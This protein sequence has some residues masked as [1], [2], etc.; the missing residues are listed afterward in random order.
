MALIILGSDSLL[1][2]T[3]AN[4]NFIR[5]SQGLI[6]GATGILM[7][8]FF[9]KRKKINKNAL[10]AFAVIVSLILSVLVNGMSGGAFLKIFLLLFG[11]FASRLVK[12]DDFAKYYINFMKFIAIVS[13]L[14][15]IFGSIIINLNV[16]PI[17]SNYNNLTFTSLFFTNIPI[18]SVIRHRNFGPFWEPGVYQAYLFI[19]L[20]FSLFIIKEKK[21]FNILL[22]VVTII[23]TFST[24]GYLCMFLL[25][26]AYMIKKD[27]FDTLKNKVLM[28]LVFTSII[29][30]LSFDQEVSQILF[31]KI[32]DGNANASFGSR[33]ESVWTNLKIFSTNPLFGVGPDNVLAKFNAF[34]STYA[35]SS[36]I[37]NTNTIF[38]HF[39]SFG[40]LMGMYYVYLMYKFATKNNKS[41]MSVLI[42]LI[43]LSI[44]LSAE[45]FIYSI[46]FNTLFFYG[47]LSQNGNH[48][49]YLQRRRF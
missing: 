5:F 38:S 22:F 48:K 33:F 44:I 21:K 8:L 17:I 16:F 30:F 19:A 29:V 42:I 40:I 2:A 11:Y 20:Y 32:F 28:F 49:S 25:I 47:T 23:T 7:L 35:G 27:R 46:L 43:A 39:S 15:I 12:F 41:V 10:Y 34:S 9:L 31:G 1:F 18:W 24:T 4:K 3:N 45:Y 6:I 14:G 36:F 37:V 13:L 26:A